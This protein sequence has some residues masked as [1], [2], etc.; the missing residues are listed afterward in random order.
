MART[1]KR[2]ISTA[3]TF[4][5]RSGAYS[6]LKDPKEKVITQSFSSAYT[7]TYNYVVGKYDCT[8]LGKVQTLIQESGFSMNFWGGATLHAACINNITGRKSN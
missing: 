6:T 8:L 4:R 5:Y 1:N 7:P 2:H 3:S